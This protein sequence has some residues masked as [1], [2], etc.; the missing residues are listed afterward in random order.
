MITKII[1]DCSNVTD[2]N[3][4]NAVKVDLEE[5]G[6]VIIKLSITSFLRRKS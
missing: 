5:D 4:I 1:C 6:R 3:N 2:V